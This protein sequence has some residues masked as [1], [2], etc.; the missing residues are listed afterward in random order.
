MHIDRRK[1]MQGAVAAS[2]SLA[3]PARAA[4]APPVY[5]GDMHSHLF[6]FG[7]GKSPEKNPLGPAM[8]AGNATLV[9]WSLVGDVP[10]L[11]IT[12][13]GI[14]Q[15]GQ[16]KRG[17]AAAWFESDLLRIKQHL[18]QQNL[19]LALTPDDVDRALA[20]EPHVVLTVEGATFVDDDPAPLAHAYELG[21]R[22][23]QLVHY[24]ENP[25]GD[26]QTERPQYG[27]LTDLGRTVILECN[28]LGMLVDL[29]H[30]TDTCVREA[31]EIAAQPLVWSHSSV[32]RTRQPNWNMPVWQAR[33]LP[34]ATA[35]L[36]AEKGGV[37]GLW[38]MRSDVGST[39]SAYAARLWELGE[40]LGVDH[41]GIGTDMNAIS[42]PA[43]ASYA[44]LQSVVREWQRAGFPDASIR[45]L[46]IGNFARVLKQAMSARQA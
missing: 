7:M 22:S 32:T 13:Q 9:A 26:F 45:K 15:K 18:D 27:G 10:W 23:I 35:R 43:I 41:A 44:D 16:P 42:H 36:I 40:L 29:A 37:V 39:P 4:D 20:G 3:L 25:L 5:I 19:K 33:Q 6:F 30:C 11:R 21:I 1:L 8:A 12:G 31:L 17:E 2:C 14:K 34:L 46:A 24:I 38:P 28:R